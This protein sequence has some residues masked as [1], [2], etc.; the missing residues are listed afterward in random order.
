MF[1]SVNVFNEVNFCD[2]YSEVIKTVYLLYFHITKAEQIIL[3]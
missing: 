1:I 2:D 3:N